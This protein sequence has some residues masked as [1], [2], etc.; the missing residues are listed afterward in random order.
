MSIDI[1]L[2]N[3]LTILAIVIGF[4]IQ[5]A[6]IS[7]RF[8]KFEGSTN[9]RLKNVEKDVD[10]LFSRFREIFKTKHIERVTQ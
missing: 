4:G 8:G 10:T 2:G 5:Y 9:A 7:Y 1:T 6:S 3:V